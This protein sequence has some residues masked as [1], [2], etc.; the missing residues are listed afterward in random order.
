VEL[1]SGTG[2]DAATAPAH[3]IAAAIPS[4][5]RAATRPNFARIG[6]MLV[7]SARQ[8]AASATVH[9]N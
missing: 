6:G 2:G 8:E 3:V 9:S 4:A 7:D 5:M 1:S